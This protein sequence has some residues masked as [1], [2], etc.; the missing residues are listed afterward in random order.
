[1]LDLLLNAD[2]SLFLLLNVQWSNGFLDGMMPIV[3]DLSY[4]FALLV[5]LYAYLWFGGQGK[6]RA[7]ALLLLLAVGTTDQISSSVIK[8]Q[9][10]RKRPCCALE[11]SRKLLGCKTSKSFPSSHAANTAAVAGVILFEKGLAIGIP[12]LVISGIVSYSR[13]YVGVHYPLDVTMGMILGLFIGF[14]WVQL[15]HR[16]RKKPELSVR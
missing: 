5:P 3:T 2:R 12:F 16:F 14:L 9:V 6:H 11:Q 1:M 8:K 7:L 4:W 13:I 15:W 10:G